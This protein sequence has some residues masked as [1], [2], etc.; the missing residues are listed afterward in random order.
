[1]T[2]SLRYSGGLRLLFASPRPERPES[3]HPQSDIPTERRQVW[4]GT[5]AVLV[6][7]I[8]VLEWRH[9]SAYSSSHRIGTPLADQV[10][11]Q[12]PCS[13]PTVSLDRRWL[14]IDCRRIC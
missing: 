6:C 2:K 7:S 3:A 12:Q 13:T 11:G 9:M 10:Y 4:Q 8:E 1:M 14:A 5:V